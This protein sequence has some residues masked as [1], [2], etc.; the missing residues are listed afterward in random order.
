MHRPGFPAHGSA[1]LIAIGVLGALAAA[2]VGFL[3]L[4]AIPTGTPAFVRVWCTW[5]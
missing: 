2:C 4:F 5:G 3:D 1:W